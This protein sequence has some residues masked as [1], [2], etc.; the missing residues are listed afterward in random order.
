MAAPFLMAAPRG[1]GHPVL[2]LPGFLASDASTD[3]MR[4]YL[5]ALGYDAHGWELGRNV[6]GVTRMRSALRRRLDHVSQKAGQP[7]SV[8][9]WSLGGIYAR[10]LALELPEAVRS[11]ISLG[12]P[13]S[14]DPNASNIAKL[15]EGVTGEGRT[16]EEKMTRALFA[17]AFD[18]IAGDLAM[19][20]TSI[21]T[22]LDGIVDWR[23]CLLRENAITENIEVIGASH[24][25]LGV[26]AAVLWAVAD[27][28]AQP[29]GRFEP[30]VRGG[31][32]VLGY[33][34]GA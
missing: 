17:H 15:Y 26:N 28:L 29:K 24:A 31:P 3:P 32:F 2:V 23:A 21:Y 12:S 4:A 18:R 7:V 33:G 6:G 13:F 14:R 8:I 30:F 9:G 16:L 25:G 5:R 10:M 11:V 20:S 1:D 22:K 27:R 19:P 34:S